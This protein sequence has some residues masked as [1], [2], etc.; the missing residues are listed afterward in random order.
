[1]AFVC[2]DDDDKMVGGAWWVWCRKTELDIWMRCVS[3]FKLACSRSEFKC[4][5][6]Y[7]C[8]AIEQ[9]LEGIVNTFC[10]IEWVCD[11]HVVYVWHWNVFTLQFCVLLRDFARKTKTMEKNWR[12]EKAI[13]A[14]RDLCVPK[15]DAAE[16]INFVDFVSL[17]VKL[18]Q[19][20]LE[21]RELRRCG[22]HAY[23]N[24]KHPSEHLTWYLVDFVMTKW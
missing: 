20:R 1:M 3:H 9:F 2:G 16:W 24:H 22:C 14:T 11:V 10:C 18:C 12:T 21:W 19:E 6:S 23:Y 15:S 5:H 17:N 8:V 13:V 7:F 4:F